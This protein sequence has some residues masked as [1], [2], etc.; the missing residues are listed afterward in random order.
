MILSFSILWGCTKTPPITII[1][2][3]SLIE[4]K[5]YTSILVPKGSFEMGCTP[6]QGS[7]CNQSSFE[8]PTC[9]P[10]N[11]SIGGPAHTVTITHDFYVMKSEV[12]QG[13]YQNIMLNNPS[14]FQECGANCPVENVNWRD[15]ITF[16]NTLSK[17]EGLEQCYEI[18]EAHVDWPNKNSTGWRLLTEAEW[19][20]AARG[21]EATKFSGSNNANEVAWY[22]F[23]GSSNGT[24]TMESTSPVCS[25]KSNGFALCD[26]SGNVWEWVWDSPGKYI[27]SSEK[28]PTGGPI[29]SE[30]IFRGG[31]WYASDEF[32]TVSNRNW[33]ADTSQW[34]VL[35]FRL[36]RRV[37]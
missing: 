1:P 8:Q 31:C 27:D 7:D 34:D 17:T 26:M 21:G 15:A 32:V 24:S 12:T 6:E 29:G 9:S 13:L 28:D 18:T 5:G 10:G 2:P 23:R 37:P 20:Y 35:G 16:A 14:F 36:A 22:G 30:R 33:R 25:K 4:N 3:S 11:C 19:E